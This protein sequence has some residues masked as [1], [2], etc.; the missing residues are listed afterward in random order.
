MSD[1]EFK[2]ESEIFEAVPKYRTIKKLAVLR[3]HSIITRDL[4]KLYFNSFSKEDLE[5]LIRIYHEFGVFEIASSTTGMKFQFS[6]AFLEHIKPK[7]EV[8]HE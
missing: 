7:E 8:E 5:R 4:L 1:S 3:P 6:K 2:Q